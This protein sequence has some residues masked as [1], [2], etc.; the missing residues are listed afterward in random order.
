MT[1][2]GLCCED[3]DMFTKI[4]L[5]I[6]DRLMKDAWERLMRLLLGIGRNYA[7]NTEE[8]AMEAGDL[9]AVS[10]E[11]DGVQLCVSGRGEPVFLGVVVMAAPAGGIVNYQYSGQIDAKFVAGLTLEEGEQVFASESPGLATN[12]PN[13]NGSIGTVVVATS[14]EGL[15]G[16]TARVALSHKTCTF[17][18]AI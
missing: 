4:A 7:T 15:E 13:P 1:R 12:V 18:P 3:R 5:A 11:A 8:T 16:D 10:T 9:V 14:Y 6:S 2:G 17:V